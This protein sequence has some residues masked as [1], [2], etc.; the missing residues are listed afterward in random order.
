MSESIDHKT[1]HAMYRRWAYML[2]AIGAALF[3][4]TRPVFDFQE[5][6]GIIYMRSFTMDKH[7]FYVTQTDLTNGAQEVTDVMSVNLLYTWNKALIWLTILCFV[8]FWSN[9]WR[10]W[11]ALITAVVAGSYY[12][13]MIYYAV[14]MADEHYCTLYPNIMTIFPAI[15]LEMMILVRH[16]IVSTLVYLDDISGEEIVNQPE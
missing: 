16:N 4:T 11:I 7:F 8:C 3:M 14:V 10:M 9:R 5:D 1:L 13:L 12:F 15:I 6:Q 2:I